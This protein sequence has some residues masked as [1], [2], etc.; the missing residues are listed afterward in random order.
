M[1]GIFEGLRFALR[2]LAK[3]PGFTAVAVLTLALG[4]GSTTAIFSVIYGVLLR[5]LAVPEARQVVQVVLTRHGEL[6][7]DAFNYAQSLRGR[8]FGQAFKLSGLGLLLGLP[9]AFAATRVM[10]T[11]IFGIV[12]LNLVMF[13]VLPSLLM[14]TALAA[15]YL[16]ARRATK[17]DP[18]VAL[19]YE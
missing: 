18:N 3:S 10:A 6:S 17:V 7:E 4:I 11:E 19:R 12:S 14:L 13:A 5:P 8:D 1:T 2:M 9:I 15:G 16:P